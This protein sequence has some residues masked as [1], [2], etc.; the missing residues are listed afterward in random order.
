LN[1]NIPG[2][3]VVRRKTEIQYSSDAMSI[4][5]V[6]LYWCVNFIRREEFDYSKAIIKTQVSKQ[7]W[8][9][10]QQLVRPTYIVNYSSRLLAYMVHSRLSC[11]LSFN[12]NLYCCY[13]Y[14]WRIFSV[15]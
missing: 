13:Q 10:Q 6:L 8:R 2:D 7:A 1:L 9:Q 12:K 4:L 11:K 15:V 14:F 5:F 3:I